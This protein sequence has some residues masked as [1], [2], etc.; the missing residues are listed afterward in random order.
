MAGV[1][2]AAATVETSAGS[3][4]TRS[5]EALP[6]P[7]DAQST[8]TAAR[9]ARSVLTRVALFLLKLT[10]SFLE[11]DNAGV[12]GYMTEATAADAWP[13]VAMTWADHGRQETPPANDL[14][15]QV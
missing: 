10:A 5:D 7:H 14:V 6:P 3:V 2:T 4:S 11:M 12:P 8:S 9:S 15:N 1:A 13:G